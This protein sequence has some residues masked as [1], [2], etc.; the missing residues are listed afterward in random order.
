[1]YTALKSRHASGHV[2]NLSKRQCQL[3]NTHSFCVGVVCVVCGVVCGGCRGRGVFGVAC[4]GKGGVCGV[5]RGVWVLRNV[6]CARQVKQAVGQI[7]TSKHCVGKPDA[8]SPTRQHLVHIPDRRFTSEIHHG[9]AHV[10]FPFSKAV[11]IPEAP[12]SLGKRMKQNPRT[13]WTIR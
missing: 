5:R 8:L 9:L 2:I 7:L 12:S 13:W 11:K 10:P 3:R 1:M 4:V 6:W